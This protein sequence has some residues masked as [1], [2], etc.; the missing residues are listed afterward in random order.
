MN[1]LAKA[2]TGLAALVLAGGVLGA[3]IAPASAQTVRPALPLPFSLL[4]T[5]TTLKASLPFES[6]G[7]PLTLSGVVSPNVTGEVAVYDEKGNQLG[8]TLVLARGA[9]QLTIPA[10]SAHSL[11]VGTHKLTAVYVGNAFYSGSASAPITEVIYP[12]W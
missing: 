11:S 8:K 7:S 3:T 1:I 5:S 2:R 4:P 6:V 9:Y 10:F 12:H